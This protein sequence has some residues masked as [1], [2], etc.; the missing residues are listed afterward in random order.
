M[1][2]RI[3]HRLPF[4]NSPYMFSTGR[5]FCLPRLS[6]VPIHLVCLVL[7]L[8]IGVVSFHGLVRHPRSPGYILY[9]CPTCDIGYFAGGNFEVN[10]SFALLGPGFCEV[11][12]PYSS[13]PNFSRVLS[14][15]ILSHKFSPYRKTSGMFFFKIS[16]SSMGYSGK[17]KALLARDSLW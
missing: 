2:K 11:N 10:L 15:F 12:E 6:P 3:R 4:S 5:L 17:I 7:I 9:L 1:T 14:V 13:C 16:R 8:V